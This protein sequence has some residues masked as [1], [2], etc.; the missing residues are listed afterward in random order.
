MV[1]QAAFTKAEKYSSELFVVYLHTHVQQSTHMYH[2][3]C[4]GNN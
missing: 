4:S 3:V 1:F 2:T